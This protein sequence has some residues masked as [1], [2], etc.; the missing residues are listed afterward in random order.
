MAPK[1]VNPFDT[2]KRVVYGSNSYNRLVRKIEAGN[3]TRR[4]W[5]QLR[6][7]AL[8]TILQQAE[9]DRLIIEVEK[10]RQKQ[11]ELEKKQEKKRIEQEKTHARRERKQKD[12]TKQKSVMKKYEY[13][14]SRT[15]QRLENSSLLDTL[16]EMAQ[17]REA[18][19][20]LE[21]HERRWR[22]FKLL[23]EHVMA[24]FNRTN[25]AFKIDFSFTLLLRNLEYDENA[26]GGEN[27]EEYGMF[28]NTNYHVDAGRVFDH[29]RMIAKLADVDDVINE[30]K[31][32]IDA[33]YIQHRPST[34]WSFVS[35]VTYK[36]TVS[37]T[38][39]HMGSPIEIPDWVLRSKHIVSMKDTTDN[40][41]F[42][43]CLYFGLKPAGELKRFNKWK[44]GAVRTFASYY[45]HSD[46]EGY[47]GVSFQRELPDIETQFQTAFDIWKIDENNQG[48]L[49]RVRRSDLPSKIEGF[50]TKGK[51]FHLL[52][53]QDEACRSH[54][55]LIRDIKK[56]SGAYVCSE[57]HAVYTELKR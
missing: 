50:E 11:V 42:W 8:E 26:E 55:C 38:D 31:A 49:I 10:E 57:C 51:K 9:V 56:F 14:K 23:K 12:L 43:A 41:C 25:K 22:G 47:A 36:I 2:T 27:N 33:P 16:E 32:N 21:V 45:G 54:L 37:Y 18:Q 20:T 19:L 39:I 28:Y 24:I 53:I 34:K 1:F 3:Y 35:F 15:R 30:M 29:P 4:G 6:K 7:D 52:L 13:K 44:A 5:S 46:V 48:K 40:L 17:K